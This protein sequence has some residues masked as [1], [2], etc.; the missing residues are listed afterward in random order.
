M[1]KNCLRNRKVS[2]QHQLILRN[3]PKPN[4]LSAAQSKRNQKTYTTEKW[5]PNPNVRNSRH[6]QV[7]VPTGLSWWHNCRMFC[8]DKPQA[9]RKKRPGVGSAHWG[10]IGLRIFRFPALEHV[11]DRYRARDQAPMMQASIVWSPSWKA[12]RLAD[13]FSTHGQPFHKTWLLIQPAG[14]SAPSTN[15]DL[16]WM[17]QN[18][19]GKFWTTSRGWEE[20]KPSCLSI[21]YCL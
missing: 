21:W 11:E 6:K 16:R 2:G 12:R 4:C 17:L 14:M 7:A 1:H 20:V 10:Q 15:P 13:G 9:L 5:L 19:C 8:H 3:D 18:P